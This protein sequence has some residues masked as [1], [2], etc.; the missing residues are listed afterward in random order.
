MAPM[1]QIKEQIQM[2]IAQP[3]IQKVLA[4]YSNAIGE[5]QTLLAEPF[6]A[7]SIQ[8]ALESLVSM[9]GRLIVAGMG[10]SGL[11]GRK[12][13]ATFSSTGTPAYFVHPAEASHGDLGMVRK[14]D[15]LLLL[16]WSGETSEL[17]DL[18]TYSRRYKVTT[19]G[20]TGNADGTL[21]KRSDIALV[22]PKLE[23]A[24]PHNLAPTTSTL[25]QLAVGDALAI[26]L[27]QMKGFSSESFRD[28][29]PGGKLGSILTPVSDIMRKGD[30]LPLV[31]QDA[32]MIDVI[33]EVSRKAFGIA[34]ITDSKGDLVGVVTDG[35]IRRYLENASSVSMEEALHKTPVRDHMTENSITITKDRLAARALHVMQ[36]A[37]ISATFVVEDKRPI[38]LVTVLQLLERGVA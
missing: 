14:E 32:M 13:A 9:E 35:D 24:C 5:L 23:E 37:K 15:I 29:H 11:I 12:L 30:Q 10:K 20:L 1:G 6:L 19:I 27:L 28:F 36:E 22:L 31:N 26:A 17:G 16:S 38:G 21:A 33:G 7:E 25:L 4:N 34:G 8:Q 3:L 18:I 2:N